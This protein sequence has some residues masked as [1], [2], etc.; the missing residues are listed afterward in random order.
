MMTS[1]LSRPQEE[2]TLLSCKG[3]G[4]NRERLCRALSFLLI[5]FL[6]LILS[7]V[8][9]AAIACK[10]PALRCIESVWRKVRH[11]ASMEAYFPCLFL[12]HVSVLTQTSL[13]TVKLCPQTKAPASMLMRC[14]E[15]HDKRKPLHLHALL[16]VADLRVIDT[17]CAFAKDV[18]HLI[19]QKPV[20]VAA[21]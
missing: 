13:R 17:A 8:C 12:L 2:T 20:T 4:E 15:A 18:T 11:D 7:S 19:L 10:V 1:V 16:L 3:L 21:I 6:C 9:G 14:R 5:S